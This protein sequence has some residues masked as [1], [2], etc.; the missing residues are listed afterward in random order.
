MASGG[1]VSITQAAGGA[2]SVNVAGSEPVARYRLNLSV[3][4]QNLFNRPTYNGYSGVITSPTFLQPTSAS[5]VRRTNINVN[6]T[7]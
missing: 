1:G 2:L 6:L 4:I 5:G 7:F 3:N